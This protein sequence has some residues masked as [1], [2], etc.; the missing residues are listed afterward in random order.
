MFRGVF[1]LSPREGVKV[2][3]FELREEK[4]KQVAAKILQEGGRAIAVKTDISN[5]EQVRAALEY[6][7]KKFGFVGVLV[8]N[9]GLLGFG[10][11]PSFWAP[12]KDVPNENF[13]KM[14]RVNFLGTVAVTKAVLP[15]MIKRRTGT[16]VNIASRYAWPEW[17]FADSAPYDASKWAVWAFSRCLR[18]EVHKY[19]I[20]VVTVH[21]G[22][23]ATGDNPNYEEVKRGRL[24]AAEDI[25]DMIVYAITVPQRVEIKDVLI[26]HSHE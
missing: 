25:A 13:E 1:H 14:M 20:R 4:G 15:F 3:I 16:I 7:E 8:N 19:N 23:T 22:S 18:Q 24:L 26:T 6:V 5:I 12:V 10:E 17:T 11:N 9:A 2:G 21:P